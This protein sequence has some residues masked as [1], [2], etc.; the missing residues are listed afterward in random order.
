M[1]QSLPRPTD[2]PIFI[3]GALA[4]PCVYLAVFPAWDRTRRR[5]TS[6]RLQQLVE[7]EEECDEAFDDDSCIAIS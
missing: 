2:S 6:P 3:P 7:E 1:P 5:R 4:L